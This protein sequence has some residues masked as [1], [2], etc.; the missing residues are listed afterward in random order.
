MKPNKLEKRVLLVEGN[1]DK[2]VVWALLQH[3]A[4]AETFAVKELSGID[5]RI[6][7]ICVRIRTFRGSQDL[8]RLGIIFDADESLTRR[9]ERLRH[10]LAQLMVDIPE[11]PDLTGTIVSIGG[12]QRLG[13]WVMPDN[14]LPGKLEDF[15]GFLVNEHDQLLP[16]VDQFLQSLPTREQCPARFPDKDLVK[17]R[18]HGWL[19]I[20]QEPGKPM[21][22]AITA[23]YLDANA[24]MAAVFV[25]WIRRLFVDE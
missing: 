18:I 22:Q 14:R 1:N 17:A 8:E 20:Q 6:Q 24:P 12:A 25:N 23:K 15:L 21:G 9:W 16:R 7:N 3:H 11:K 4:V 19:A 10:Q 2:H 5:D 13:V